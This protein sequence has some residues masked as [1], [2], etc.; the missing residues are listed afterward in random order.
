MRAARETERN[1][2]L[3]VIP[4]ALKNDEDLN[5]ID[6]HRLGSEGSQQEHRSN[7]VRSLSG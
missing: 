4:E 3:D 7:K 5:L 6:F 2:L 1:A